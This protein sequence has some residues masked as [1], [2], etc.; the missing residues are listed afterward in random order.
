[1]RLVS[2]FALAVAVFSLCSLGQRSHAVPVPACSNDTAITF[3]ANNG[4]YVGANGLTVVA[5]FENVNFNAE[6]LS[7]TI[8]DITGAPVVRYLQGSMVAANTS[9]TKTFANSGALPAGT[10][11]VKVRISDAN[12]P[13]GGFSYTVTVTLT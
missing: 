3:P 9:G 1:M 8:T 6:I 2:L 11:E 10:Y 5:D 7:L 13:G 12:V 4:T